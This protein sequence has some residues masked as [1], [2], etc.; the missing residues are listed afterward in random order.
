MCTGFWKPQAEDFNP[1]VSVNAHILFKN[2][3][4]GYY[5][6][7]PSGIETQKPAVGFRIF[8]TKGEYILKTRHA[9]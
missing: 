6:Y 8:G 2:G 9:E 4:I 3:V 1:Y 5:T 7:Y